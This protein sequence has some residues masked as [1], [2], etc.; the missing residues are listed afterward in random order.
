M[1]PSAAAE[2]PKAD[3]FVPTHSMV[4]LG[5]DQDPEQRTPHTHHIR[6]ACT[7]RKREREREERE[8]SRRRES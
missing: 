8:K 7:Q 5:L 2:L 3:C 1:D 6:D 4:E